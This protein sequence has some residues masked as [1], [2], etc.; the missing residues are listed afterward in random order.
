M[1]GVC[2]SC[3]LINL[4]REFPSDRNQKREY[5]IQLIERRYLIHCGKFYLSNVPKKYC[6]SILLILDKCETKDPCEIPFKNTFLLVSAH[7]KILPLVEIPSGPGRGDLP[8][9]I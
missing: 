9:T 5:L 4:N 1:S 7:I 8:I 3:Q 2:T 6:V